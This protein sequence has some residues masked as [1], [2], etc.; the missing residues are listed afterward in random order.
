[1]VDSIRSQTFADWEMIIVEDGGPSEVGQLIA[2][3]RDDRIHHYARAGKTTLADALN[4][5]LSRC[6]AAFVAR[7]DSDDV[8]A[9]ERLE[10]QLA[11]L[12]EHPTVAVIGSALAIIDAEGRPIGH[13]R[14][15]SAHEEVAAALRRYNCV[16]HPAVMFR[17][18]LVIAAGAYQPQLAED[19][20]LWC[21]MVR[22]GDR[23]ENLPIELLSY[24]FHEDALK[25]NTVRDA[26]RATID[27]KLR[28][29]ADQMTLVDRAR[30][31]AE[32]LLLLLPP[33]VVVHL[34]RLIEYRG[35]S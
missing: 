6:S 26:I 7:M 33:R 13:R 24:R 23:I 12:E 27:T 2:S 10:R 3:F 4:D 18:D 21:R 19:Y 28:H 31:F 1:A 14:L 15:P 29:F 11:F 9:R 32:R 16:A 25:F 34:F 8:A 20:D 30:I 22:R 5:G 35:R 17:I